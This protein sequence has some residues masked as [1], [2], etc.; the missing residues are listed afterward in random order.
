MCQHVLFARVH[1]FYKSLQFSVKASILPLLH[2][3]TV[4][5]VADKTKDADLAI[6]QFRKALLPSF[7]QAAFSV[8]WTPGFEPR[9]FYG[10]TPTTTSSRKGLGIILSVALVYC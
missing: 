1:L 7:E 6:T 3:S 5:E 8:N 4:A 2:L 10:F 9:S